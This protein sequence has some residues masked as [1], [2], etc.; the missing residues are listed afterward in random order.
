MSS[1]LYEKLKSKLEQKLSPARFRHCVSVGDVTAQLAAKHG[2]DPERA[3]LAGLLH[4][5]AKEW[6]PKKMLR[7]V[8]KH[9]LPVPDLEFVWNCAPNMM[10]AY[11]A[12]HVVEEK[13]WLTKKNDLRAIQSHTLGRGK[14]TL[15]E[16]I[17]F[18]ADFAEPGRAY[19]DT[20][21]AIRAK[22]MVDVDAAFRDAVVNKI[23]WQ[24]KKGKPIHPFVISV[25]NRVVCR[26]EN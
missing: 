11:V 3:R 22:A 18:I 20:A 16:K 13:G 8:K 26:V 6:S 17:L 2:W 5:C 12:A 23:G 14:M 10:H 4:D 19:K 7:Y 25:W 24:L 1:A 9:K 15:E 21:A